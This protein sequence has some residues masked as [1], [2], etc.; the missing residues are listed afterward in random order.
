MSSR[1][2]TPPVGL[3]IPAVA[4]VFW[5]LLESTELLHFD[6]LPAPG[7][8]IA[9][10]VE[11]TRTGELFADASHTLAMT[12]VATITALTLGAL[13]GLALGLMPTTRSYVVASIDFLRAIPA[14]TLI[15]VA[16]IAFGPSVMTEFFL[17]TYAALWPV[18]LCTAAGAG[19][20]HPRQYNVARMLR[21]SRATTVRK[22]VMP[23]ACPHGSPE[24]DWPPSSRYSFAS[25]SK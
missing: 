13:L 9:S 5:Q 19:A 15:P 12:L 2:R 3:L 6:Y 25:S 23:S 16:V 14:V 17:A 8:V 4:I 24:R 10:L 18:V 20:N 7:D 1:T 11:L 22:I 21:F